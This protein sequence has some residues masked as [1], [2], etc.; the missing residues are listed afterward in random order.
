MRGVFWDAEVGLFESRD[1]ALR[2]EHDIWG[3]AFAVYLGV[4]D[5]E[6]SQE[7]ARVL[8][9]THYAEIVQHGQIRHHPRRRLLGR[10]L[11]SRHVSERRLLR[12]ADGLVSCMRSTWSIPRW[13]D[14]TVIDMVQHFREHGA[15]E[16]II[17]EE[18]RLPNYLASAC[19]PLSGIRAMQ[20]RRAGRDD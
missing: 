5:A 8:R 11:R 1:R 10:G 20:E 3:S 6:Q 18:R 17:G 4:A 2:C 15:C 12:D 19:L 13:A 14:Q 9:E 16:W 7:I